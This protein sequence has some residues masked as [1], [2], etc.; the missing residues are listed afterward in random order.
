VKGK[1][2]NAAG[3]RRHLEDLTERAE[4][5]E[6]RAAKLAGE[7]TEARAEA[8][9]HIADLRSQ[10]AGL[11]RQRDAVASPEIESVQEQN[12]SLRRRLD[13][14]ASQ[15]AGGEYAFTLLKRHA[16]TA[17]RKA[18]LSEFEIQMVWTRAKD[19]A[20]EREHQGR[21]QA[22]ELGSAIEMDRL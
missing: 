19:E 14:M 6:R 2:T 13:E 22:A 3:R 17:L 9:K 10:V 20:A 12:S 16:S 8:E 18:G 1:Y 15:R 7:L 4:T 5:A 21:D 11:K